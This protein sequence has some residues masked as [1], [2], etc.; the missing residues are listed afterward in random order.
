MHFNVA[1]PGYDVDVDGEWMGS[2]IVPFIALAGD[3]LLE[4]FWPQGL[5]LKRGWQAIMDTCYAADNLFNKDCLCARLGKDPATW[6]W[7]EH[8]EGFT[9]QVARNFELCNRLQVAE[10]MGAGRYD[11]KTPVMMQMKKLAPTLE[12]PTFEVEIDPWTRYAPLA[13]DSNENEKYSTKNKD[14]LVH[15]RVSR[16]LK[17]QEFYKA[18]Q[19][20]KKKDQDWK[21]DGR[22]LISINGK[23]VGGKKAAGAAAKAAAAAP[24]SPAR[25]SLEKRKSVLSGIPAGDIAKASADKSEKLTDAVMSTNIEAHIRKSVSANQ[26]NVIDPRAGMAALLQ[27]RNPEA[28]AQA[29][30]HQEIAAYQDHIETTQK[31]GDNEGSAAAAAEAMWDRGRGKHLDSSQEAELGK[32]QNMIQ[33]LLNRIGEFKQR[34]QAILNLKP[35]PGQSMASVSA[36][37]APELPVP[38]SAATAP[39]APPVPKRAQ[40]DSTEKRGSVMRN[41]IS[42]M[43]PGFAEMAATEE[44]KSLGSAGPTVPFD[45]PKRGSV[46]SP[47]TFV[48]APSGTHDGSRDSQF[49][50]ARRSLQGFRDPVGAVAANPSLACSN[51]R[52]DLAGANYG[53]CKCGQPKAEH[54]E[55]AISKR[56]STTGLIT[57]HF[58]TTEI[59]VE[60]AGMESVNGL[61]KQKLGA[62]QGNRPVYVHTENPNHKVQ[63]DTGR[64][65]WIVDDIEGDAPY[66]LAGRHDMKV[67]LNGDWSTYQNGAKPAPSVRAV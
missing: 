37:M 59:I 55:D 39:L 17:K 12:E 52:V 46:T 67:P 15:P 19:A 28:L 51:Y 27:G 42:A 65:W 36:V 26:G 4:P 23:V 56:T 32:I 11:A 34:E 21:Y 41:S 1:P 10:E 49:A 20:G 18:S 44:R 13:R 6:T 35:V 9:E 64:E 38:M 53:D 58:Q 2:R 5:G 47:T 54:S 22:P 48:E 8:F 62:F 30:A 61:Y 63:W 14:F 31:G 60:G 45:P 16:E 66:K 25:P 40:P 24:V 3:A 7:D 43:P 29:R 33:V 57:A 50:R